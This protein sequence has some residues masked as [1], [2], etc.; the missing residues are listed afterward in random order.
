MSGRCLNCPAGT[1][2]STIGATECTQC[3]ENTIS[4]ATATA[5]EV[6]PNGQT[7][8]DGITCTIPGAI[9]CKG[10]WSEWECIVDCSLA[11]K[12]TSSKQTYTVT[13]PAS[14]GGK[15]CPYTD[16][17]VQ[18]GPGDTGHNCIGNMA[19]DSN[20]CHSDERVP[21]DQPCSAG[22]GYILSECVG[23][24]RNTGECEGYMTDS[25]CKPCTLGKY[26]D[27]NDRNTCA[28][29]TYIN[30]SDCTEALSVLS[31][32]T[33]YA[34]STCAPCSDGL[35]VNEEGTECVE[36][37]A[38]MW[39]ASGVPCRPWTFP[40]ADDCNQVW[41][42][43]N[44]FT[45]STCAPCSNGQMVNAVGECVSCS[46][47]KWSA[48][49]VNCLNWTNPDATTCAKGSFWTPGTTITDSECHQC[50]EGKYSASDNASCTDWSYPD[51]SS[52]DT[53]GGEWTMGT[54]I[55]D[56]K[57]DMPGTCSVF[58]KSECTGVFSELKADP[59]SI[60]CAGI[61][62]QK[63]ECC[64]APKDSLTCLTFNESNCSG[65]LS[66][67]KENPSTISCSGTPCKQIECCEAEDNTATIALVIF[68]ICC[69]IV[70]IVILIILIFS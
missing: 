25:T 24:K 15:V 50:T 45:N 1:I 68:L 32:G 43:G 28:E 63:I 69:C 40:N 55:A 49:G 42:K 22:Y 67:L 4:N 9:D 23:N 11:S 29:W 26:S 65:T 46:G 17:H 61:P 58:L 14:G 48:S 3:V 10:G 5:C 35:T 16:S 57:C 13:T 21:R 33:P 34:D 62:C 37:G 31:P 56:S 2:S 30:A 41:T 47:T 52:C 38:G 39:S 27:K 6:C 36:C 19:P 18:I 7:S 64:E 53:I 20:Y 54:H 70:I 8:S 60:Q 12:T 44:S 59:D 66:E 51:K